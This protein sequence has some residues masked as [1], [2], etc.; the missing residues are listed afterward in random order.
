MDDKVDHVGKK[1]GNQS[2]M[3]SNLSRHL[4]YRALSQ[5][6]PTQGVLDLICGLCTLVH[7]SPEIQRVSVEKMKQY[8]VNNKH[9]E[10]I[11]EMLLGANKI[12]P[13]EFLES[14]YKIISHDLI[15]FL[16]NRSSLC[17]TITRDWQRQGGNIKLCKL[18]DLK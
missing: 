6:H 14:R 16:L 7:P 12:R 9:E 2:I 1:L 10:H 13:P 17:I 4:W 8:T 15:L 3:L 11:F 18:W 5:F